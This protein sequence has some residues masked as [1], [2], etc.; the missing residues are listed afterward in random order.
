MDAVRAREQQ[1][2]ATR[3]SREA[4]QAAEPTGEGVSYGDAVLILYAIAVLGS[5]VAAGV[6]DGN[7]V[8]R[9]R[10]KGS[11]TYAIVVGVTATVP[12]GPT[13]SVETDNLFALNRLGNFAPL[14]AS[15][16]LGPGANGNAFV[17]NFPSLSGNVAGN[18]VIGRSP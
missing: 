16:F 10:I 17:G 3:Q 9:N 12:P 13:V 18:D 6:A 5:A 1:A 11:G 7:I 4:H 8:Y 14:G 15:L 2:F